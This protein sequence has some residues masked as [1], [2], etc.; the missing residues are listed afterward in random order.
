MEE[1]KKK[2]GI[3]TVFNHKRKKKTVFNNERK[4]EKY[5]K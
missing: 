1:T 2:K 4:K 5:N 3:D